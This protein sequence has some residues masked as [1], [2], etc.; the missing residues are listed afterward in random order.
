MLT[1]QCML[2]H[3]V[4]S[5]FRTSWQ[6]S[7][8]TIAEL[9]PPTLRQLHRQHWDP[10]RKTYTNFDVCFLVLTSNQ[11]LEVI[12]LL[13]LHCCTLGQKCASNARLKTTMCSGFGVLH[14]FW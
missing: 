12:T 4:H 8:A 9:T 11:N 5:G 2:Y 10:P 6:Y 3:L 14:D 7:V 13:M 1:V